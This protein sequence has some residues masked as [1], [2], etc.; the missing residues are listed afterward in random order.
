M[1][2]VILRKITKMVFVKRVLFSI[3]SFVFL[4]GVNFFQSALCAE[5]SENCIKSEEICGNGIDEDCSGADAEC[6]ECKQNVIPVGGCICSGNKQYSGFCCGG[7]WQTTP[8]GGGVYYLDVKGDDS[9]N[10]SELK[11]WRSLRNALSKV[12]PGDTILVNPGHHVENEQVSMKISGKSDMPIIVRGNGKGAFI[13]LSECTSRNA[14]EISFADYIIIDNLTVRASKDAHSRGIR[15]THSNGSILKNSKIYGAGH[16]NIFFSLSDH[17]TVE[18]NDSY[19]GKVGIY[20][21]DSSD[22]PIVRGNLLH[23]NSGIGLHM[24]GDISSGG[25]GIISYALVENNVIYDNIQTGINCDGVTESVFRNNLLYNNKKRGVAFFKG[26]GAVPSNDNYVIHN[27]I[28]MPGG[29]SYAIGLNYGAIRDTFYN[30]II[31]TEGNV[32]CFSTTNK[33]GDLEVVSDY[34]LFPKDGRIWEID[35]DAYRFGKWQRKFSEI[36]NKASNF[37]T[38]QSSGKDRHSIQATIGETFANHKNADFQLKATS[39]AIDKGIAEH[40]FG[41][42]LIGNLRPNGCCPDIGAYEYYGGRSSKIVRGKVVAPEAKSG[43]PTSKAN[44]INE[45]GKIE[46]IEKKTLK[47]KQGMEFTFIPP[48]SFIM[49]ILSEESGSSEMDVPHQVTLSKGF[50]MQT[51]EV[52]QGQW[53]AIMGTNPSFYKECGDDCPVEQ[54]SWNDAQLFIKRLNDFEKRDT[55]RLPT[56]AEWE[57]AC[58]AGTKTPFSFGECLSTAKA[59]YCGHYPLEGCKTGLYREKPIGVKEFSSNAWGLI[60]MHGNVWEWCQDWF[61]QYPT[62]VVVDSKGPSAGSSKVIR[63]GGWNSYASACRSGNR[64]GTEPNK[65]FANLGFRL[66]REE[67][68]K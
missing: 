7:S 27:T 18:N 52:T 6:K 20:V 17:I 9:N 45:M 39:T 15:F 35:D 30:N 61:G 34:N 3:I 37:V 68:N 2:D 53:K 5:I 54:V 29:A 24:N 48:G 56:E 21:A 42:D 63:G 16:A 33:I 8:C 59:N 57:Y 46:S 4:I 64:S 43:T 26:D 40:S 1:K 44:N 12:K 38:G 62:G 55:Y 14:F 67:S 60:D 32:P 11:P 36:A 47:N 31:L 51:T 25:D 50:Y 19:D 28:I 58:R 23:N 41:K 65:I 13:D 66:V 22:Y 49:G 10:G